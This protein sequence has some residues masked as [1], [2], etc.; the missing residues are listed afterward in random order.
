L[1]HYETP[2]NH[3]IPQLKV[4]KNWEIIFGN[5]KASKKKDKKKK[6]NLPK[7]T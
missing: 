7:I 2:S 6:A 1:Q 4:I 3:K 5:K